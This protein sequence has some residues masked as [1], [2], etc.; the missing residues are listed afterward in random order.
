MTSSMRLLRAAAAAT[1]LGV[2]LGGCGGAT[3]AHRAANS[4]GS[5]SSSTV[6]S[7]AQR[8]Q[9][10]AA[11]V[12]VQRTVAR[13]ISVP[14]GIAFLPN[15]NALVSGRDTGRIVR[16]KASGGKK[17]IGR[18]PGVVSN[19]KSGG[20]AGLL[21]LALSPNFS[22]D[23]WLY[24][25][26][27]TRS[28]NRVVRMRY[29]SGALGKPH[30]VV[31]GIP[32]GLH[33]NGGRIAFGPDK[34]LY[35][36]TGEGGVGARAQQKSSLG[37]KI[38]RMTATGGVPAG[39]PFGTRV[40]SYGHRNIE[41]LAWDSAGRLWATEFGEKGWDELNLIKPGR[42]YGWPAT[43]GR[44]SNPRYTSP[45]AQWHTDNAGPSGIA[46]IHDVAWIGGLTGHRLWRV[47]LSGASVA[48]KR[49][50]L[51]DRYGR[52]RTAAAA[53]DGTLWL[54][55]SNTDGRANPGRH[56]DRILQLKVS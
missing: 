48:S 17:L 53:P 49:A 20:E 30:V 39:N 35:V 38:L 11:S 8:A 25:Y 32:V 33:H 2:L 50:F 36:T 1:T 18:V 34:L 19:G 29:T 14:W 22:S 31:K 28:D 40:Y 51:L 10:A 6:T 44:T 41:G 26:V 43:E 52:V 9:S 47:K 42:N 7:V 55:T 54:T 23:H 3:G 56:D 37:G 27:S 45:K 4:H 24:A 21:G 12:T 16:V 15:G 46:I 5:T 13:D